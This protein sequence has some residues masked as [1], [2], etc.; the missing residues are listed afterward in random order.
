MFSTIQKLT[1]QFSQQELK[2]L[3]EYFQNKSSDN[4]FENIDH[5]P[6]SSA[7]D[8]YSL[9]GD[10]IR[11]VEFIT[12]DNPRH[13]NPLNVIHS[14]RKVTPYLTNNTGALYIYNGCV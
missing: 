2:H 14:L 7:N 8:D 12:R 9:N 11:Q 10:Y 13:I 5:E 3:E 1:Q 4:D 6:S